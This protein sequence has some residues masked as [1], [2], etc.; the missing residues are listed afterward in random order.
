MKAQR[1]PK[2]WK[3]GRSIPPR[4]IGKPC[5][6]NARGGQPVSLVLPHSL[7]ACA[8]EVGDTVYT[9][10]EDELGQESTLF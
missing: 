7:A 8:L 4:A 10:R 2:R 3:W 9:L 1:R 5:W 6:S